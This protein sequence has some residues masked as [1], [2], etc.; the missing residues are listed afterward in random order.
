MSK[1]RKILFYLLLVF[2]FLF[3]CIGHHFSLPKPVEEK[4][5]SILLKSENVNNALLCCLPKAGAKLRLG[6]S[7]GTLIALTHTPSLLRFRDR[8]CMRERDSLLSSTVCFSLK[9]SA[10]TKDGR[11]YLGTRQLPLGES[12]VLVGEN[13]AISVVFCGISDAF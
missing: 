6:E 2:L 1:K 12:D 10:H 9:V 4:T 13:F 5:Y 8:G 3:G 11:F 7:D